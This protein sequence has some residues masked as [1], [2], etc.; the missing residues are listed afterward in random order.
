MGL[1]SGLSDLKVRREWEASFRITA[2]VA[3]CGRGRA[4]AQAEV[5]EVGS[6]LDVSRVCM[7]VCVCVCQL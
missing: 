4:A 2:G 6:V 5:A 3:T 1:G 7:S